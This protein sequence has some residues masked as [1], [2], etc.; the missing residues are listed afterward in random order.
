MAWTVYRWTDAGAPIH[1][2]LIGSTARLYDAVLVN[3]Y[4]AKPGAGWSREFTDTYPNPTK[5]VFRPGAAANSRPYWRLDDAV[6]ATRSIGG[7]YPDEN[8]DY[9][10]C[11]VTGHWSISGVDT[12]ILIQS[13]YDAVHTQVR[14]AQ[15]RGAE[16]RPWIICA[17]ERTCVAFLDYGL[18]E[19]QI[20]PSEQHVNHHE[21]DFF[22]MGEYLD[23]QGPNTLQSCL[24]GP[25]GWMTGL[26]G[27]LGF[28]PSAYTTNLGSVSAGT[29]ISGIKILSPHA[30]SAMSQTLGDWPDSRIGRHGSA[31]PVQSP[32]D[33]DSRFW[34]MP[35]AMMDGLTYG[36]HASTH[37]GFL[38][39]VT[40]PLT[41]EARDGTTFYAG[42]DQYEVVRTTGGIHMAFQLN[43][44][45]HD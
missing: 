25:E 11:R 5:I 34:Y 20:A 16:P 38:R 6:L 9:T 21:Y 15:R 26:G 30:D 39:G 40:Y 18:S 23:V 7:G 45:R 22:Y 42:G 33:G 37:R 8:I 44:P 12:Y 4:G 24:I 2:G 14:K 36:Y 43:A 1:N 28:E 35:A 19:I 13:G 3:G 17:D 32:N 27:G 10:L 29:I 41:S 31:L